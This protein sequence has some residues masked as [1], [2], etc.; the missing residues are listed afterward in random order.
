MQITNNESNFKKPNLQVQ[1]AISKNLKGRTVVL[2]AHRLSTVEN[3]DKIIVINQ[4]R[5]IP[6]LL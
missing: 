5:T 6:L 3:A 4:V 1:E 2:I